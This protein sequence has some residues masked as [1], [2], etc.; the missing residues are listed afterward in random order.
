MR[1]ALVAVFRLLGNFGLGSKANCRNN[2]RNFE[3]NQIKNLQEKFEI[4]DEYK[5]FGALPENFW[6]KN[7]EE[8]LE[9]CTRPFWNILGVHSRSKNAY[10]VEKHSPQFLVTL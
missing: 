6:K 9:K 7:F 2:L 3:K 8:V 4:F 1:S 5:I 10:T